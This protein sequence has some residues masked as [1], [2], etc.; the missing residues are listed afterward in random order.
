MKYEDSFAINL[1]FCELTE[2]DSH[3]MENKAKTHFTTIHNKE[4]RTS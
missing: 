1:E 4:N 2:F 3:L